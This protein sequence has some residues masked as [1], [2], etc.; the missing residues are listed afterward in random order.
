[1]NSLPLF[2]LGAIEDEQVIIAE[3]LN[4]GDHL[5]VSPNSARKSPD[6]LLI[7]LANKE[8]QSLDEILA[9]KGVPV[10]ERK[11]QSKRLT[12]VSNLCEFTEILLV[13]MEK[14]TRNNLILCEDS[15]FFG[16][17]FSK[18]AISTYCIADFDNIGKRRISKKDVYVNHGIAIGAL[19][20]FVVAFVKDSEIKESY[21]RFL[22]AEGKK[23]VSEA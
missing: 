20:E 16:I 17:D 15:F 23:Y 1:M 3:N 8:I 14:S 6:E 18:N 9:S 7:L 11:L 21:K 13:E 10:T 22:E 2:K 5:F 19:W 12:A 4:S